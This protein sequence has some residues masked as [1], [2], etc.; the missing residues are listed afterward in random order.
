[1][2]MSVTRELL[3][4]LKATDG[5]LSDYRVAKIL[6]VTQQTMTKYNKEQLSLAPERILSAC[7]YL[8]KDP[9]FWLLKLQVE[10]AKC[11]AEKDAWN[12]LIDRLAA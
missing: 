2:K 4:A 5:G 8:G 9:Y 12:N 3:D 10:R 11:D 1:M 6:G 7:K